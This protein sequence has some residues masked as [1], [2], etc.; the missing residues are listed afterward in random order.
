MGQYQ[1]ENDFT[2]LDLGK[3][4]DVP[5]TNVDSGAPVSVCD[6]ALLDYVLSASDIEQLYQA[7]QIRN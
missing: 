3:C 6:I 4:S 7:G 1:V 2:K 5:H